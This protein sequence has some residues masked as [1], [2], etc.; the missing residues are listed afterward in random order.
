MKIEKSLSKK[1]NDLNIFINENDLVQ[2]YGIM[3]P[4][5]CIIINQDLVN[6]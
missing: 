1:T 2:I 3:N 5:S 6:F 4:Q